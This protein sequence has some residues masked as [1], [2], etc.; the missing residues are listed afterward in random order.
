MGL[1]TVTYDDT[2]YR[3]VPV[4]PTPEMVSNAM[5]EC[6]S[7]GAG[8]CG[9][10][11]GVDGD[12]MRSVYEAMLYA[13][14]AHPSH[15]PPAAQGLTDEQLGRIA[16]EGYDSYWTED[17]AGKES[18]AWAASARAVL[19]AFSTH[20]QADQ[21]AAQVVAPWV[22][23]EDRLPEAKDWYAVW[24]SDPSDLGW[25]TDRAWMAWFED[26]EFHNCPPLED[27][28][29]V[30]HWMRLAA[31]EAAAEGSSNV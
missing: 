29:P 7:I 30:T 3:L 1:K 20:P 2:Q 21:Q 19:A 4:E 12:D 14:P 28:C 5:R 26:G 24:I 18:D 27:E 6:G 17:C 15:Q 22:S 25:S 13:A 10:H 23:I 11:A 16:Y 8:S 9:E 31:P